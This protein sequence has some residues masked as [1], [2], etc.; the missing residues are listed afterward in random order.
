[1][2]IFVTTAQEI[3]YANRYAAPYQ[4]DG[5]PAA[6]SAVGGEEDGDELEET[7]EE[8]E[9]TANKWAWKR[10][11][12]SDEEPRVIY[13]VEIRYDSVHP[14]WQTLLVLFI[15]GRGLFDNINDVYLTGE[16]GITRAD[17]LVSVEAGL[18]DS[19]GV[20]LIQNA[21]GE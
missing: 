14:T 4:T 3:V 13:I 2:S 12:P 15:W 6:P 20:Q 7:E 21:Y 5:S 19:N 1:M 18:P 8:V 11:H 16:F 10:R 17:Q 9:I